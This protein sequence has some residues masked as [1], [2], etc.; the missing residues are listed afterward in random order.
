MTNKDIKTIKLEELK[1]IQKNFEESIKIL[2]KNIA[3]NVTN[4]LKLEEIKKD[5]REANKKFTDAERC[6]DDLKIELDNNQHA[7]D[8]KD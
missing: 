4:K 1:T 7:L 2:E 6:L 8:A 3:E 5:L